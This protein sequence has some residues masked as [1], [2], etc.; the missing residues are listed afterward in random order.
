MVKFDTEI[1]VSNIL[2]VLAEGEGQ[3]D[4]LRNIISE[5][6]DFNPVDLF[7]ELDSSDKG[8]LDLEDISK[9]FLDFGVSF[10]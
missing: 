2:I 10:S 3:I 7:G 5:R 8:F 1:R 4:I 9:L 6:S